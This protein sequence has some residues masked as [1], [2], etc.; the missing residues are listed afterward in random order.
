MQRA[1]VILILA[2]CSGAKE[3][4]A[5]CDTHEACGFEA[6]E[7]EVSSLLQHRQ[8]RSSRLDSNLV[9]E[10][11]AA[12]GITS[13]SIKQ[14]LSVRTRVPASIGGIPVCNMESENCD[15]AG[16][17]PEKPTYLAPGGLTSCID[18]SS[19]YAFQV[20]P[21]DPQKLLFFFQDGGACFDEQT[22]VITP[23]CNTEISP[24]GNSGILDR[25]DSR[26]R[27]RD[28]TT[29]VAMYCSGDAFASNMTRNYTDAEGNPT[30]VKQVG[31]Q[32][33]LA[34]VSWVE[35]QLSSLQEVVVAGSSS[36]SL[37]VQLWSVYFFD[38]VAAKA[39][40]L[41]AD[42]FL[43]LTFAGVPPGVFLMTF[44]TCVLPVL[45]P[46]L[47][48]LCKQGQ[49][50][51]GTVLIDAM[52]A[53]P[54]AVFLADVTKEDATQIKFYNMFA[55]VLGVPTIGAAEFTRI[56]NQAL[57]PLNAEPNFVS[58]VMDGSSHTFLISSMFYTASLPAGKPCEANGPSSHV[59]C[60]MS[61]SK[62]SGGQCCP[63]KSGLSAGGTFPCPSAPP[64]FA[65]CEHNVKVRNCLSPPP[66]LAQWVFATPLA[67]GKAIASQC[68][69][70]LLLEATW[71]T[72]EVGSKYCDAGQAGKQA[73]A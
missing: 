72:E 34:A 10:F 15:L 3:A 58:Y 46:K 50:T 19:P 73:R 18:P 39:K 60:P 16:L 7:Q 8:R 13:P 67:A 14:A 31:Y 62:C 24:I 63:G 43:S 49:V 28:W 44:G 41:I 64:T 55:S 26:N 56:M 57:E 38:H 22:T 70:T 17:E 1:G 21:G 45:T 59:F 71:A 23:T 29:V 69:G 5:S 30:T 52:R 47:Q 9:Q 25:G 36:G 40:S 48:A 54:E 27:Y 37:G 42:S 53:N 6:K 61:G 4:I 20:I 33:A 11:R 68:S 12:A 2:G 51:P 35:E 65:K 66:T 32:N